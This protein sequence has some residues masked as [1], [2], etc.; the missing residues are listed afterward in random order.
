MWSKEY[1]GYIITK[2]DIVFSFYYVKGIQ[3]SSL[4]KAKE[5]IDSQS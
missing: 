4:S 1:K 2:T 5:W 3:F